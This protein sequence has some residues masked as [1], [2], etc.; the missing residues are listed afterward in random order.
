MHRTPPQAPLAFALALS[1]FAALGPIGCDDD[2]G[3]GA[4]P[5][6][7]PTPDAG[8]DLDASS[9]S[10]MAVEPAPDYMFRDVWVDEMNVCRLVREP[11]VPFRPEGTGLKFGDRAG[12]FTVN[13]LDGEQ[14]TLSERWSGCESYVFLNYF[15]DLRANPNGP[16]I[17]DQLFASDVRA[18]I[19]SGPRN[20]HYFFTSYEP[21]AADREARMR[22][23]RERVVPGL[24]VP[25]GERWAQHW[26]ER[27]HFVTDRST[28]MPGSVGPFF[29]AYLRFVLD[30]ANLV[31]LGDRGRAQAPL[32]Q[33]F[34][35]DRSQR[36]D[37]GGSLDPFVGATPEF[38]MAGYLGHYYNYHA[39]LAR[40]LAAEADE[41]TVV[42]L[43]EERVTDRTFIRTVTLPS[44]DAMDAFD[45]LEVDVAVDCP[46]QN[47]F[48]CSEWDRIAR[49]E[50][51]ADPECAERYEMVRWITPYWRRG[52]RRWIMDATP[53]IAWV[54]SGGEQTFRVEMG[55][56]WERHTSRDA[57]ISLR[58]RNQGTPTRPA[59]VVRAFT[60][61]DFG[62]E[63]N[64]RQPFTFMLPAGATRLE[65]VLILSGHGQ[66]AG[67]NC[68]EWC[69]HQHH[70]TINGAGV[71]PVE[72][73][74]PIGLL[75]TCAERAMD[76]VPPG[77]WG[78]WAPGRAYWCPGLPVETMRID[79]TEYARPGAE[80]ELAY[81]ATFG[82]LEPRGGEIALSAYLV[83]SE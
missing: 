15:P 47:P 4:D 55:P 79:V 48:A 13:L 62:A 10:D 18:M 53:F 28:E 7:L 81:L 57:S 44:A 69:D 23:L 56:D 12:D 20:V 52:L 42:P 43:L 33:V 75:R 30:P 27:L 29:D 70:F 21:E 39:T 45:T 72:S 14:W 3:D 63:Y 38:A 36:W 54:A 64:H 73:Q 17:G 59:G 60:G 1:A 50:W 68:A 71:A 8:L 82:R 35:I 46:H 5:I 61:G 24:V 65:L 51:C 76:G 9:P 6:V 67:D 83:W 11:E 78:N 19:D 37:A 22:D 40:R 77:Q 58:L 49:I 74:Q 32:L 26:R 34:G 2:D 16:W 41:T 66:T 25:Y 80:N 31:D